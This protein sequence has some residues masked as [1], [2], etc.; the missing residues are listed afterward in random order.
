MNP[1]AAF[2]V[3][4]TSVKI[5]AALN[6]YC[7]E[8]KDTL[9]ICVIRGQFA[10]PWETAEACRLDGFGSTNIIY[11]FDNLALLF[12]TKV[13]TDARLFY[14]PA[15]A[16]ISSLFSYGTYATAPTGWPSIPVGFTS[17]PYVFMGYNYYPQLRT[18][19]VINDSYGSSTLP[20]LTFSSVQL[21]FGPAFQ[22]VTPAKLTD[23]NPKKSITTDLLQN[24]STLSHQEYGSPA[25]VNALFPDGHVAFQNAHN[26]NNVRGSLHPFDPN[27]WDPR[28]QGSE[29][30]FADPDGFRIIMNGFQP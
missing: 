4:P 18:T 27:L 1:R 13:V 8:S 12:R 30:P 2:N 24:W 19:E 6:I 3:P 5:G 20:K 15:T 16:A 14:C 17:N 26:Q 9:P 25:G 22:A 23:I 29:G 11:G 28:D 7:A 10:N 21:E